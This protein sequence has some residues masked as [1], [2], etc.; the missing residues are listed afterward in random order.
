MRQPRRALKPEGANAMIPGFSGHQIEQHRWNS[1]V[2]LAMYDF[3]LVFHNDFRRCKW[4]RCA[5]ISR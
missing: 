1:C 4:H 5:L 3:L 2:R